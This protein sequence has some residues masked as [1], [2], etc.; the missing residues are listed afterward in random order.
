M[1]VR[2]SK[3]KD[4]LSIPDVF[5]VIP[6][7]QRNFCWKQEQCR[8]LF[9]DILTV[10]QTGKPHFLGTICYKD[11]NNT[12][13]IIDGQQRITSLMLLL[14][15]LYDA[16][17]DSELRATIQ[18]AYLLNPC[19]NGAHKLKLKPIQRDAG[20]Y[21]RLLSHYKVD[22]T[23]FTEY[24]MTTP[25][26]EAFMNYR[27]WVNELRTEND[28]E[29]KL[30]SAIESLEV[31]EIICTSE[32]PQEIFE[33]LNATGMTLT[34]T[35]I[36]RN[37]L[38]MSVP[39]KEQER[40]YNAYW[41]PI[42]E[43]VTTENIEDFVAA[44]LVTMRR[45]DDIHI[46]QKSWKINPGTICHTFR[47]YF[48]DTSDIMKLENLFQSMHQYA[49]YYKH[50]VFTK[51]TNPCSLPEIDAAIYELTV[52]L[53]VTVATPLLMYLFNNFASGI[54]TKDEM[55]QCIHIMIS[56]YFRL[57]VCGT[58]RGASNYQFAGFIMKRLDEYQ[59]ED[60]Y[61]ALFKRT[62]SSG[63]GGYAFQTDI[64]FEHAIT[65]DPRKLPTGITKYMLY[66]IEKYLNPAQTATLSSGSI[67]HIM[68][69]TLTDVWTKYLA[70]N[71][72]SG[73][74]AEKLNVLGNLTLTESNSQL[75]NKPF[76][77]KQT[78]Y[79][80][81]IYAITA[82][83]ASIPAWT[84]AAIDLR[85][86][87]LAKVALKVWPYAGIAKAPV[88]IDKFTLNDN[89]RH[90]STKQPT[91][92]TFLD[93]TIPCRSWNEMG[94]GIVVM[95]YTLIPDKLM[96][97][98]QNHHRDLGNLISTEPDYGKQ[99][100]KIADGLW[101]NQVNS[102]VSLLAQLRSLLQICSGDYNELNNELWFTIK[103]DDDDDIILS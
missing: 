1:D 15:A 17:L 42:E 30:M 48:N 84:S 27:T 28:F 37:Y 99:N 13:V 86:Q 56:Y 50:C 19:E 100:S 75:S 96:E 79:A 95:L 97:L 45:S 22:T 25:L 85:S 20:V 16:S 83:L 34:N 46:N 87:A 73:M 76:G 23:A 24:E 71:G 44:Y 90:L 6:V 18:N 31:A 14:K 58:G 26:F 2:K 4:F 9:D 60:D 35:D 53:K 32:N 72:D 68:P 93:E 66:K 80:S 69:Q 11:E 89:L 55:L 38:L 40:L 5:F 88:N 64:L 21:K 63:N 74:H 36:L 102:R 12:R 103:E 52:T 65:T 57:I 94:H 92:F 3:I 77:E 8:Q 67:E 98:S 10:I 39:Y 29:E 81:S 43:M 78:I 59:A 33:S 62:I 51:N 41:L 70:F 47:H 54:I 101:L 49:S 61:V 91:S 82:D 7:Y